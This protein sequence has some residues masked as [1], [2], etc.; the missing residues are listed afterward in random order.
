M[1]QDVAERL[2]IQAEVIDHRNK[3]P[4]DNTRENLRGATVSLNGHNCG[5]RLRNSTGVKGV[6]FN[7]RLGR[8]QARIAVSGKEMWLGLFDTIAEAEK[9][10]VAKR[11]E[12]VG[13]FA[14]N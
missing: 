13:E 4:L 1:S 9:V 3:N 10:V 14:C 11:E 7:K 5:P 12:L 2:G 6:S 8:Y